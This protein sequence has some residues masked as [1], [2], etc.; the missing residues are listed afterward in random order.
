MILEKCN[1]G[2]QYRRLV[3]LATVTRDHRAELIDEQ[4]KLIASLLL[5]EIARLSLRVILLVVI[6]HSNDRVIVRT[7]FEFF[8]TAVGME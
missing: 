6:V 8:G 7:N 2:L 3:H 4:I 1:R 5:A